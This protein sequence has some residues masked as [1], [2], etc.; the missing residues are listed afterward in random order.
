M[1][2]AVR[3]PLLAGAMI[4]IVSAC[5]GGESA[6]S[7]D[8]PVLADQAPSPGRQ[9]ASGKPSSLQAAATRAPADSGR[10]PIAAAPAP[11]AGDA[12]ALAGATSFSPRRLQLPSGRAVPILSEGT[13]EDGSLEVPDDPATVGWWSGGAQPGAP[14]GP[15]VLA[16]HIDSH[17]YGLGA[18]AELATARPGAAVVV[19][20]ATG[21]IRYRITTVTRVPKADL[22]PGTDAFDQA[23]RPR[24]V[25]ITCGGTFDRATH[26]YAD[27]ILITAVPV[28]VS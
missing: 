8:P 9:A 13:R 11:K 17:A 10:G 1:I 26:H 28:H 6:R 24:L 14:Y 22:V 16:G 2:R 4:L 3:V 7:P 12:T 15:T 5:G 25:L 20:G 18:L 27:N 19:S 23:G 21:E